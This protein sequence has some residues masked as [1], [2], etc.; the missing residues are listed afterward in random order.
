[1][2]RTQVYSLNE[3]KKAYQSHQSWQFNYYKVIEKCK[4]NVLNK[5]VHFS[6]NLQSL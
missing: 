3:L 2:K 6:I 5:M 4:T 1:M